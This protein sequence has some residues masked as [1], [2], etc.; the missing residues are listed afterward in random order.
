MTDAMK[1]PAFDQGRDPTR[2]DVLIG[3]V[4]DGEASPGDWTELEEMAR[5]DA[6]VWQRL[7]EAQRAHARFE[8][9]VED[10][11]AIC[12]LVELP[13]TQPGA[14]VLRFGMALRQYGGWAAA[15][16][17]SFAWLGVQ[18]SGGAAPQG[19]GTGASMQAAGPLMGGGSQ[20]PQAQY[21][22]ADELWSS[23]LDSGRQSGRVLGELAPVMVNARDL[24]DGKGTEVYF[25]RGVIERA[26][27]AEVRGWSLRADDTG[28]PRFVPDEDVLR[29]KT[30]GGAL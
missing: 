7:A 24:G 18:L 20:Q 1:T 3:R 29:V 8:Q 17:V 11:I 16:A 22:S 15:A 5:R 13:R 27:A 25:I 28:Q 30:S 9:R 6:G 19:Y 14:G 12:E 23:Y 26:T 21:V 4:T 10:A 2:E